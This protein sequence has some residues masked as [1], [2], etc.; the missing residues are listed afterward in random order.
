MAQIGLKL[1]TD[2]KASWIQAENESKGFLSK[3]ELGVSVEDSDKVLVRFGAGE[4]PTVFSS[5]PIVFESSLDYISEE[6]RIVLLNELSQTD[7]Y[8]AYENGSFVLKLF[9]SFSGEANIPENYIVIPLED[10]FDGRYV[11]WNNTF[12]EWQMRIVLN[13]IPPGTSLNPFTTTVDPIP[14]IFDFGLFGG[15]AELNYDF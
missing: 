11:Y 8:V 5:C 15:D 3:G 4:T 1:R 10:R 9:G 6:T 7:A 12:Q 14:S 2:N 13:E